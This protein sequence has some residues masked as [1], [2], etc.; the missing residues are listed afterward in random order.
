MRNKIYPWH[1]NF[2]TGKTL[3]KIDMVSLTN[4]MGT[5]RL[6]QDAL[7]SYLSSTTFKLSK[8]LEVL[9]LSIRENKYS[10]MPGIFLTVIRRCMH[11]K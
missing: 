4:G 8:G 5:G 1:N 6:G 7:Y 10:R 9:R 11:I 3:W 2:L